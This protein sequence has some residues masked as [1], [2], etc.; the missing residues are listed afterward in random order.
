[1]DHDVLPDV[2][3]RRSTLGF[4][5]QRVSAVLDRQIPSLT[6]WAIATAQ[7]PNPI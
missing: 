2:G 5:P 7:P 6:Y 3:H 1:V 4:D